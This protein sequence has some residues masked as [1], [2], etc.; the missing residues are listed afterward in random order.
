MRYFLNGSEVTNPD[1]EAYH[2]EIAEMVVG[3]HDAVQEVFHLEVME[4]TDGLRKK[5]IDTPFSPAGDDY[6]TITN[7]TDL[8]I[9]DLKQK[10]TETDYIATKMIDSLASCTTTLGLIAAIK[11]F[12]TT[13][14]DM[15]AKRVAWR[16]KIQDL[17]G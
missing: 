2:Q 3:H 14:K 10:L 16:K 8:T 11:D 9:D 7:L 17:G 4:G 15:I 6:E 1:I 13:Y 12:N 5:V